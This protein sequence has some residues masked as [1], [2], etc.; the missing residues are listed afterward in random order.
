M[1]SP[2]CCP[3]PLPVMHRDPCRGWSWFSSTHHLYHQTPH[4]KPPPSFQLETDSHQ[5]ELIH[6]RG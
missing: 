4:L 3:E 1:A 2:G 5:R 6:F